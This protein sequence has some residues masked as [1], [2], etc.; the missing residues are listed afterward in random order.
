MENFFLFVLMCVLLILLPGP[1]F[2]I[3]T[4]NTVTRGKFG[5]MKTALGTCCALLIHTTAAI[6]GLSALIVKSAFLFSIFKY[7]G[8]IYLIYLGIKTFWSLRKKKDEVEVEFAQEGTLSNTSC[9]K[10]GFLT[11][12]LNPKVA[13]FFLTFF[14]QFVNTS[15]DTFMPFLI[16][17]ITYTILTALWFIFYIYLIDYISVFIKN[18]RTQRVIEG[19]T[20][21]I[22]IGFGLRLALEKANP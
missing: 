3:V 2:A 13:L 9:F 10:Q 8:A 11:N 20:G 21:A 5:G 17:G 12:I 1:D 6:L 7:V 4:K 14:P 15:S 16:M 22:L 18:A 19:I